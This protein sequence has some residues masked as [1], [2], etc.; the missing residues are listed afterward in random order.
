MSGELRGSKGRGKLIIIMRRIFHL[1]GGN[2]I[3]TSTSD[4][5][6]NESVSSV[7]S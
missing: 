3:L 7:M 6:N 5:D 2:Y 1:K 4:Y